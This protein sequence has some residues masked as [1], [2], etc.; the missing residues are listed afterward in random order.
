[1]NALN[2][3]SN[4]I[5]LRHQKKITQEQLADYIGVTKASVSKWENKQSLPDILILPVL[6]SFFDVTIDELLGYEPQL[7]REQIQ[8]IYR[9]L[10]ADFAERPFEEVMEHTQELIKKYDSCYPFL[11]Q[12]SVLCLNHFMLAEGRERQTEILS[13][14]SELCGRIIS[15]CRDIG[16]SN[17]AVILRASIDMQLGNTQEVIE[18]L[19]EVLSPLRLS[20][21]SDGLLIQA[22]RMA[23][24]SE[25]ADRFTQV[26]MF[27]HLLS[28]V[29]GA[30][31][32]MAIHAD[33]LSVCEETM[34]RA[35]QIV[36]AY[37]LESLHPNAAAMFYLQS[38]VTYAMHDKKQET[39][40]QLKRYASCI[41]AL[42][43]HEPVLKGDRYFSALESWFEQL[44][45]GSGAPRDKKVIMDSALQAFSHPAFASLQNDDRYRRIH[46]SLAKRSLNQA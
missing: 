36:D 33:S 11:F 32:H 37:R 41:A 19:E 23:G 4:L 44:E 6:A 1:M 2:F 31:Q 10:A 43:E 24:D 38:A 26:S 12:M 14:L 13:S 9:D 25:K 5:R 30:T 39:L 46:D 8:K 7:S 16:L 29:S 27:T 15:D 21:Q 34:R 42:A 3:S 18:M 22:Y 20:T 28:L 40:E 45:L 35:G 17:D